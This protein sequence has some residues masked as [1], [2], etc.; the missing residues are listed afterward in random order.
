M[1]SEITAR[2]RRMTHKPHGS[3]TSQ[4]A[5]SPT[6]YSALVSLPRLPR[7]RVWLTS[8]LLVVSTVAIGHPVQGDELSGV[9]RMQRCSPPSAPFVSLGAAPEVQGAIPL[10]AGMHRLWDLGV[11]WKDVNP[12]PGVFD[13]TTLDAEIAQVEQ[14]GS[15][16]LLVLGMT[17]SWAAADPSAGDAR[18]GLGTASPP[19]ETS[20]WRDYVSAVVDRYGSRIP[21]YQVWNEANL[22]TFWTGNPEQMAQLTKEAYDIIKSKQPQ[23]IVVAPSIGLRLAARM[24]NFTRAFMGALASRGFPVDA[25]AIHTYPAGD[26][27]PAD[28]VALVTAWQE[29]VVQSVGATS[30][31]LDLPIYDTE[32]NYGLAGPG[33]RPGRAYSDAEAATLIRQTYADSL[34]LGIDATFWY[35]YTAAPFPVLGVQLWSGAPDALGAWASVS[36]AFAP[37]SPCTLTAPTSDRFAVDAQ[38]LARPAVPRAGSAAV[39]TG[40]GP[41]QTLPLQDGRVA[42]GEWNVSVRTVAGA[43]GRKEVTWSATGFMPNAPAYVW[44]GEQFVSYS[45]ADAQG[46]FTGNA[47]VANAEALQINGFAP[48]GEVRSVTMSLRDARRPYPKT[49]IVVDFANE[50]LTTKSRVTLSR[51]ADGSA[52]TDKA[53]IEVVGPTK[54][55]LRMR[56]R[57]IRQLLRD[58]G[59]TGTITVK[60]T[61]RNADRSSVRFT[62]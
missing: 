20:Y 32:V 8:T 42:A 9:A 3:R 18:W 34:S 14:S 58:A 23:A 12:A 59:F 26:V 45:L 11:A 39:A 37:G 43:S 36:R 52:S 2:F 35:L 46:A 19:R 38:L 60:V 22:T 55:E 47:P 61:T 6:L 29:V 27:G 50:K 4:F 21:A 28:R 16:P 1:M 15:T 49:R 25:L 44:A 10:K 5:L 41:A 57:V 13:W 30:P 62:A 33:T 31:V 48:S 54:R 56:A 7:R 17:P 40:A 24:R 53:A 51:W